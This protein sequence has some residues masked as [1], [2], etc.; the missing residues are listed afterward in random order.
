MNADFDATVC[1]TVNLKFKNWLQVALLFCYAS[2]K[3]D[4]MWGI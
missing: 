3:M 4:T 1:T 2:P